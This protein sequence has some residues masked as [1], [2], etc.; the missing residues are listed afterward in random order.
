MSPGDMTINIQSLFTILC[1][2][3][4]ERFFVGDAAYLD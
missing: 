1:W 4:A 2:S 3:N